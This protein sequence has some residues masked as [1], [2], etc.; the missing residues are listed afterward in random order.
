MSDRYAALR[1]AAES[2]IDILEYISG[3]EPGDIDGDTVE[4][5]FEDE[6]GCDTGCDVSI[7]SQCQSAAGVM[8][9]LLAEREADKA[10]IAQL[11]TERD[12]L[13]EGEMGDATHSNTRAAADIYFQL[14]EECNIPAGGSL[15]EYVDDLRDRIAELESL[16]VK[17]PQRYSMLHRLDFDEPYHTEMV[18]KQSE[19]LEALAAAGITLE[20]GV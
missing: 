13:R 7:V 14:V 1:Q 15:V 9:L 4:L 6:S 10:R 3:Y 5:R 11:E 18:Y 8:R 12:A 2:N 16:K 20:T 19:V 17:L